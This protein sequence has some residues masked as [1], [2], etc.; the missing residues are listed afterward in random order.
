M[1]IRTRITKEVW[2]VKNWE[3]LGR[4]PWKLK[5]VKIIMCWDILYLQ[6]V[7]V[8]LCRYKD[9]VTIFW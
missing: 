3:S 5:I 4:Q 9:T 8:I 2:L 1:K 6:P 7:A